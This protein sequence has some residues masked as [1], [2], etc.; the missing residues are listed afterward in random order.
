MTVLI[1][2][3]AGFVGLNIA[4]ALLETGA[5]VTIFDINAP[6]VAAQASLSVLKGRLTVITSDIRNAAAAADALNADTRAIVFGAAITAGSH[7]EAASPGSI[8]DVNLR[9]VLPIMERAAKHRIRRFI[10]LSSV[11][12]YGQAERTSATLRET[13][14]THP[15]NLYA[16][17]KLA[18]EQVVA[19]LGELWNIDVCSLRLSAAFGPW[20]YATGQRDTLS[21]PYQIMRVIDLG[22]PVLLPRDAH[23]DWVYS[24]DVASAVLSVLAADRLPER[25]FNVSPPG[26]FSLLDWSR[27]AASLRGVSCRLAEAGEAANIDLHSDRDRLPMSP[28]RME[29]AFG[30]KASFNL[31]RSAYSLTQWW[32]QHSAFVAETA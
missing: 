8:I 6:P 19:R 24:A 11:A 14:A 21:P 15:G 27:A 5:D 3:G 22:G 2:G 23:R 29:E 9:S 1:Y 4:H 12:V 16:I 7:R 10:N 13:D 26:S 17:T 18:S 32:S 28:R 31:S 20:E 30:W 25:V